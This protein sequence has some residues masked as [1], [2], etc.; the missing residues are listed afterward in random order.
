MVAQARVLDGTN[1]K[2][3][4]SYCLHF[5]AGGLTSSPPALSVTRWIT[6]HKTVQWHL[7]VLKQNALPL[8][9]HLGIQAVN[10]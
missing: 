3:L 4:T 5:I 8:L 2:P 1:W 7:S 9:S 6:P 10:T